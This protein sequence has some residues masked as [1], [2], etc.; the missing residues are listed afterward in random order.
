MTETPSTT[1]AEFT[2]TREFDAPREA[3]WRAWTDPAEMTHWYHPRGFATP[4]ESISVDLREGGTYRYTMVDEKTGE[5]YPTGGTYLEI[6]EPERLVFTWGDL[7]ESAESAP[8]VT[9]TLQER[10][11]RTAM[12]FHLRGIAG[13]PGDGYVH[14]GWAE[15]LDLLI[16]HLTGSPS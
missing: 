15:A 13:H 14:D 3:V 10:G 16:E 1:A 5:Q 6:A 2:I 11:E 7:D 9:V 12:T 4:P 8:V